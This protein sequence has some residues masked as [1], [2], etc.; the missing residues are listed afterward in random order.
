MPDIGGRVRAIEAR[1]VFEEGFYL[2]LM[3]L[4]RRGVTDD[5]L[6][7]LL[8]ANVRTPD[9]TAGDVWAQV[10]AN[11]L[12]E[13]RVIA[14]LEDYGLAGLDALGDEL[15]GRAERAMR[16]AIARYRGTYRFA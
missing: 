1:E 5:T 7:E 2:P 3:K 16:A 4:Q 11:G 6:V 14:L 12:M 8:R 13:R 9:Q 10:G 15:F